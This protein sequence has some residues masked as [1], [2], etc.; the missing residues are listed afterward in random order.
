MP[1]ISH[2]Y[3][4]NLEDRD[5]FEMIKK[6]LES[7]KEKEINIDK[8]IKKSKIKCSSE[9]CGIELYLWNELK[10]GEPQII[11][12]HCLNPLTRTI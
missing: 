1:F 7:Y 6:V 2:Y 10:F 5:S 8:V 11:C 3:I 9:S 12:P 4:A